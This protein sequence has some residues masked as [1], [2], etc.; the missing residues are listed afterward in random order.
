MSYAYLELRHYSSALDCANECIS[1]A[2]DNFPDVYFRRSQVRT[3]NKF[4]DQ[5]QLLL[6]L[7][8]VQKALSINKNKLYLQ[9]LNLLNNLIEVRKNEQKEKISNFLNQGIEFY[10]N[11]NCNLIGIEK[12]TFD[13]QY[14]ILKE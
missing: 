4:S 13:I 10:K 6:A 1:Y 12:E 2:D 5:E 9:H 14:K 3:F 7:A 11:N 8:D